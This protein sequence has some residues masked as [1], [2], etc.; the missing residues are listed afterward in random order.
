ME[1]KLLHFEQGGRMSDERSGYG[2]QRSSD[3]RTA[4]FSGLV[5]ALSRRIAA[6]DFLIAND[7]DDNLLQFKNLLT[8][9]QIRVGLQLVDLG[10]FVV[11]E[12]C[13]R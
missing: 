1:A 9:V 12:A 10:H 11:H 4:G 13:F 8:T 6:P 2:D 3:F 5:N 7:E